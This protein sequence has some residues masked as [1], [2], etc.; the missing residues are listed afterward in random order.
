MLAKLRRRYSFYFSEL[1][2]SP[3]R[4]SSPEK[5][6]PTFDNLNEME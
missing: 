3:Y 5:K 1:A 6:S 4:N 2:Y